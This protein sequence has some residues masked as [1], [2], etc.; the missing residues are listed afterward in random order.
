MKQPKNDSR[1]EWTQHAW[2][3]MQYYGMSEGRIKRIVR[4]P[5]RI[6]EGIADD[7]VAVMQPADSKNYQ[8]LWVM[9]T[10]TNNKKPATDDTQQKK[11]ALDNVAQFLGNSGKKI[12]VITAWRYPGKSPARDPIPQEVLSEIKNLL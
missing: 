2:M 10:L 4:F 5:A 9:Y 7:T 12:R 11:G 6:E 3:K 8:E 1:Y